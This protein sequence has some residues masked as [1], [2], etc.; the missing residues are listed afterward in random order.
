MVIGDNE[1]RSV[2]IQHR[3]SLQTIFILFEDSTQIVRIIKL[4]N[5]KFLITFSLFFELTKSKI[6]SRFNAMN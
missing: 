4:D 1:P 3:D 2:S 5:S 6:Y